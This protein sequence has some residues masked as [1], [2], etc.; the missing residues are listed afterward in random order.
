MLS[1]SIVASVVADEEPHI[2]FANCCIGIEQL[3][4]ILTVIR[5]RGNVRVTNC[6]GVM[7]LIELGAYLRSINP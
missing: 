3:E 6:G 5:A 4:L 7:S 2:N 1:P